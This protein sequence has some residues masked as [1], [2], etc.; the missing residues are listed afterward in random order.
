MQ[1]ACGNDVERRKQ[2]QGCKSYQRKITQ[3][4]KNP[5]PEDIIIEP[6][7]DRNRFSRQSNEYCKKT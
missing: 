3:L 7:L 1:L 5:L 6:Y 2:Q 4:F